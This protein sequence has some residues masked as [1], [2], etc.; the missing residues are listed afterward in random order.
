MKTPTTAALP[1]GY[2]F[3]FHIDL[4]KDKRLF[5]LVNGGAAVIAAAM[6]GLGMAVHPLRTLFSSMGQAL[7]E[8]QLIAYFAPILVIGLG[9]LLYI[10]LHELTH[11]IF[12]LAFSGVKPNFGFTGAYAY[13]GSEVYF[14]KAHYLVIAL[15]PVVLLGIVLAV[16]TAVLPEYWFWPIYFIQIVNLSGAAGDLYVTCRFLRLP[17]DILVQDTGIAMTVFLK[18]A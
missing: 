8:G 6:L 16:L 4:Q 12:M 18:K 5:A 13:A 3:G 14:C 11:G 1:A 9:S 10:I 2:A 15:A 7:E 17:K